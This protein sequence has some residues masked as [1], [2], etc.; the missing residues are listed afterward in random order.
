VSVD[1][2]SISAWAE[3]PRLLAVA[4][5]RAGVDLRVGGGA[6]A[7]NHASAVNRGRSPRGRRSQLVEAAALDD[8]GSISAWAEEPGAKRHAHDRTRVDLRVGGG[9]AVGAT[10]AEQIKGRSPRGRRSH[11]GALSISRL[12]GSISAWAEEPSRDERADARGRVDLRVGGGAAYRNRDQSEPTGRSPRG[13]RSPDSL[14]HAQ[15]Y[16]GSISAWAEEPAGMVRKA[17][18]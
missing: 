13:R 10:W 7:G 6:G 3:E 8:L 2:G 4:E 18:R 14:C 11:G 16:R 9:A 17:A 5:W 1:T 15:R 12:T